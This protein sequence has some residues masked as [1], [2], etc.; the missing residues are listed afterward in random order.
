[1]ADIFV[2]AGELGSDRNSGTHRRSP[3]KTLAAGLAALK[4]GDRLLIHQGDTFA[5]T[6]TV[7]LNEITIA[8]YSNARETDA[9]VVLRLDRTMKG[10][11]ALTVTGVGNT[12]E[13]I[14][15]EGA[16]TGVFVAPQAIGSRFNRVNVDDFGYGYLIHGSHTTLNE[17]EIAHGRMVRNVTTED[18][19]GASAITLWKHERFDCTDIT[20]T[21]VLITDAWAWRVP[22]DDGKDTDGDGS[23]FEIFGGVKDVAITDATVLNSKILVEMGGTKARRETISNIKFVR[24]TTEGMSGKCMFM[25]DPAGTFGVGWEAVSF[26]QCTFVADGYPESPFFLAGNHGDLSNKLSLTNTTVYGAAQL[27][28]GGKGTLIDTFKH[29]GLTFIRRDGGKTPGFK[30]GPTD[31]FANA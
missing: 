29:E 10:L 5:E 19:V 9:P 3:R 30:L 26:D 23:G 1:M 7:P 6:M 16:E 13:G 17:I 21:N 25:N 11:K 27:I 24:C 28:N 14:R 12:F 8:P 22:K 20:I 4:H 2:N 18:Y 31:R 15:I